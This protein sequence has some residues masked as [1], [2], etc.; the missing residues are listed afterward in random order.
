MPDYFTLDELRALPDVGDET[1]FPNERVEAVAAAIVGIIE[2]EVETSFVPR[3]VTNE[4][5]DGCGSVLFLNSPYVLSVTEVKVGGVAVT[6]QLVTR[7]GTVRRVSGTTAM[8]WPSGFDNVEV[9]YVA[10]YSVEPPP[11]VKEQALS[12]TRAHLLSTTEQSAENARRTSFTTEYGTVNFVTAGEEQPTGYPE[13]D[14][15]ILAWK[16]KLHVPKAR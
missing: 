6:D 12:G 15:M 13:V 10:G 5:H 16:R 3:Q 9:S 8:A 7:A 1:E 11:D 4:V 14:A 2:R